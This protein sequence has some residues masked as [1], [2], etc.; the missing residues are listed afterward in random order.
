MA[1]ENLTPENRVER[2]LSGADLDPATRLEYFLKQAGSG[3]GKGLPAYDDEDIG[4]VLTVVSQSET[5]AEAIPA[6]TVTIAQGTAT[7]QNANVSQWTEGQSLQVI[8]RGTMYTGKITDAE[9]SLVFGTDDFALSYDSSTGVLTVEDIEHS[10]DNTISAQYL[11][12][13]ANAD[14]AEPSGGADNSVKYYTKETLISEP[15]Q[16]ISDIDGSIVTYESGNEVMFDDGGDS[17]VALVTDKDFPFL[18]IYNSDVPFPSSNAVLFNN[19][20]LFPLAPFTP[21]EN[22]NKTPM[23]YAKSGTNIHVIGD[24]NGEITLVCVEDIVLGYGYTD[25]EL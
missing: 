6:Q 5:G 16:V 14:W 13:H 2:L 24:A 1:L 23:F 19:Y 10:G 3:G 21:P 18:V 7:I 4:K 9:G 8:Y 25:V 17:F 11:T 12:E 20:A 22:A 15:I